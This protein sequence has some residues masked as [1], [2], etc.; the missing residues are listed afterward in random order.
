MKL[1][2][3]LKEIVVNPPGRSILWGMIENGGFAGLVKLNGFKT[4]QEA[5]NKINAIFPN[6]NPYEFESEIYGFKS[7][8]D[9]PSYAYLSSGDGTAAFVKDLSEF[10]EG[11][12]T[13]EDWGIDKWSKNPPQ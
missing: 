12:Q 4:S 7:D 9:N 10:N 1:T 8:V 11:F 3:I 5:L 2:E 6:K 13:E